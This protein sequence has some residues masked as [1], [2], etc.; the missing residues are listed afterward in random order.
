MY[1]SCISSVDP[2]T[3]VD[4]DD[5]DAIQQWA[6]NSTVT[7]KSEPVPHSQSRTEE[8]SK[9][10]TDKMSDGHHFQQSLVVI[11]EANCGS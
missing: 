10:K 9:P 8:D 11:A 4:T 2:E 1:L 5:Y 6:S 7:G 3:N